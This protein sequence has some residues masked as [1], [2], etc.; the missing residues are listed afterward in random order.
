MF[1]VMSAVSSKLLC[2]TID[3]AKISYRMELFGSVG[4]YSCMSCWVSPVIQDK[5]GILVKPKHAIV[6]QLSF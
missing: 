4:S 5:A 1:Q 6:F 2:I 3:V